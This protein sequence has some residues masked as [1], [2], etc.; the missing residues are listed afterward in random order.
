MKLLTASHIE[1]GP[2]SDPTWTVAVH[3]N[4]GQGRLLV[5]LLDEHL[6]R[7][8]HVP[9]SNTLL[10][11]RS[12]STVPPLHGD[13][14]IDGRERISN[15]GYPLRSPAG[16]SIA[17]D[18]TSASLATTLV[19]LDI[20]CCPSLR[21]GFFCAQS[22]DELAQDTDT[23][24][25]F[26]GEPDCHEAAGAWMRH[27]VRRLDGQRFF[28]LGEKTGPLERTER[29]Y[30]M[31]CVDAMGY[32]AELSDPLYKHIPALVVKTRHSACAF[33]Y[34]VQGEMAFDTGCERSNYHGIY[35]TVEAP[36]GADLDMYCV[37]GPRL[38]DVV[39]RL[40]RLYGGHAFSPKWALGYSASTMAYTDAAEPME[41][42]RE[43]L[44]RCATHHVPCDSFQLSSGYTLIDGKRCVFT[45]DR[46][47]F[48]PLELSRMFK[49]AQ[50]RLAANVKPCLLTTHPL[51][52]EALRQRLFVETAHGEAVVEPFWAGSGSFLDFLRPQTREWWQRKLS[53]EVLG[54]GIGTAWNDNNEYEIASAHAQVRVGALAQSAVDGEGGGVD[55][56]DAFI[57]RGTLVP[58]DRLRPVMA[59]LMTRVSYEAQCARRPRERAHAIVRSG[60]LGVQ[61]Y[62]QTWSGDNA[63]SW[64]SLKWNIRMASGLSLSGIFNHSHDCGGFSGP[65]PDA[66]LLTRWVESVLLH[67]R[68]TMHSW[69]DDGTATMPW[70]HPGTPTEHVVGLLRLRY[71]LLPHLYTLLWRAVHYHEPI[72]LPV[73]YYYGEEEEEHNG[74]CWADS[75]A[76]LVGESLLLAPVT[77]PAESTKR[78]WLPLAA[79]AHW[80]NWYTGERHRGAQWIT[81]SAPVG[82]GPPM[83]VRSGS[84]MAVTDKPGERVAHGDRQ[85]ALVV[86][87]PGLGQAPLVDVE[88]LYEDDG[89]TRDGP[90]CIYSVDVNVERQSDSTEQ[91][92]VVVRRRGDFEPPYGEIDVR[93]G[94]NDDRELVCIR[95]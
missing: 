77:A 12:W 63:T 95:Q 49:E 11:P 78:V 64:H 8:L 93:L 14:P 68:F 50:M 70:L 18:G 45:W 44:A 3:L 41:A 25:Y 48:D 13:D 86:F 79:G 90:A 56:D 55:D 65:T 21:L 75:D 46:S 60:G 33:V 74:P 36:R 87:P 61:R 71:S 52:A 9:A 59:L 51:Y 89:L 39:P 57:G 29:R 54:M 4:D 92:W 73:L 47:R 66:E 40:A 42:F 5:A 28:G 15:V 38:R 76:Y 22:G 62:A 53:E 24:A 35:R 31:A 72:V 32:N 7:V 94:P 27:T 82:N 1:L 91:V 34:D 58:L 67:P 26:V 19:R 88:V 69:K 83:F 43:F 81:V 10:V 2:T 80:T 30:R 17:D 37:A 85:R 20:R 6:I 23:N 84:V 16:V